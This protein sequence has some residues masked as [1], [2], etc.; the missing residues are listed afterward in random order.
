L[1]PLRF[2]LFA[3]SLY[4]SHWNDQCWKGFAIL[5]PMLPCGSQNY[6]D[7]ELAKMSAVVTPL[8]QRQQFCGIQ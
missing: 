4:A 6:N 5:R 8:T 3:G 1:Q 2:P 7:V